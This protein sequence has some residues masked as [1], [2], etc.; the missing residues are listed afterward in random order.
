[1]VY[2][3]CT[4]FLVYNKR[5][6]T[7]YDRLVCQTKLW[8]RANRKKNDCRPC[9]TG[10]K[11]NTKIEINREREKL[12]KTRKK[13]S[14]FFYI[15]LFFFFTVKMPQINFSQTLNEFVFDLDK[16]GEI[17]GTGS[18]WKCVKHRRLS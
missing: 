6:N 14:T 5:L 17:R 7:R 12:L 1:M 2:I 15:F 4:V 13:I 10:K 11:I 9:I 18:E 8:Q 16:R 3:F